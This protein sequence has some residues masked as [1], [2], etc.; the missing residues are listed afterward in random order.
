MYSYKDILVG[1]RFKYLEIRDQIAELERDIKILDSELSKCNILLDN[2]TISIYFHEKK[3]HIIT[4]IITITKNLGMALY[5]L[6]N[7]TRN[8][9]LKS[10]YHFRNDLKHYHILI[11]NIKDF[12][13]KALKILNSTFMC[14][15]KGDTIKTNYFNNAY[16]LE[17]DYNSL[18]QERTAGDS[19]ISS[20]NY[21]SKKDFIKIDYLGNLTNELL[22]KQL[23]VL[24]NP[25][26]FNDYQREL[27]EREPKE[28][29][30]FE[31]ANSIHEFKIEEEEKR[32]VLVKR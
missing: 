11:E 18:K 17:Y 1:F 22:N 3:S 32:L 6:E 26:S 25:K 23:G 9:D 16:D 10:I 28:I 19:N 20:I 4:A 24:Y 12:N 2:D 5:H 15:M 14:A 13:D 29:V 30:L 8:T 7:L 27:I 21:F 31:D